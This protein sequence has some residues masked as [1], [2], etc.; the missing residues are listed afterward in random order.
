MTVF[1]HRNGQLVNKAT[2]EPMLT[3]EQR[4]A[5]SPCHVWYPTLSRTSRRSEITWS[6]A[7]QPVAKT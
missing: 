3:E 7:I 1:V 5:L 6:T 2:G 4:N